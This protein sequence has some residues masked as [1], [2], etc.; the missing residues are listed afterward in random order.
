M[1]I[2]QKCFHVSLP[3]LVAFKMAL[4]DA[5]VYLKKRVVVQK[6]EWKPKTT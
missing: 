3:F 5:I 4:V 6:G 2:K 1:Y